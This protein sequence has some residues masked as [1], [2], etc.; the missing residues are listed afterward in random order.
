MLTEW[1]ERRKELRIQG[2]SLQ[3]EDWGQVA[4]E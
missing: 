4:L 3:P 2:V 1:E